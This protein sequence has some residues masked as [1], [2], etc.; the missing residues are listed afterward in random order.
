MGSSHSDWL[1]FG[2]QASDLFTLS[3]IALQQWLR[4]GLWGAEEK[5][6]LFFAPF[7]LC[8]CHLT[9]G[10]C[11][12][13][14]LKTKHFN[15]FA[16]DRRTAAGRLILQGLQLKKHGIAL[17]LK[18]IVNYDMR[19]WREVFVLLPV[20]CTATV[21]VKFCSLSCYLRQEIIHRSCSIKVKNIK[22]SC[23]LL[24]SRAFPGA[25]ILI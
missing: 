3:C 13:Q 10:F 21:F 19:K 6:V 20:Y 11:S 15:M 25:F 23:F 8:F 22:C 14:T 12:P 18:L 17:T 9:D 16:V 24:S 2:K 4:D 7:V 1:L 5:A